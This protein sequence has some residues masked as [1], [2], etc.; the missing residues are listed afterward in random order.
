MRRPRDTKEG[1]EWVISVPAQA[2]GL[3]SAGTAGKSVEGAPDLSI[4]SSADP[5][6]SCPALVEGCP[7]T[8]HDPSLL[9]HTCAGRILDSEVDSMPEI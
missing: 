9:M 2:T 1:R 6:S 3:G 5:P 4:G 7:G 8:V